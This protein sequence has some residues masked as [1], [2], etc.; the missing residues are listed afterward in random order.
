LE[1]YHKAKFNPVESLPALK[2][3]YYSPYVFSPGKIKKILDYMAE[4]AAKSTKPFYF[5]RLSRYTAFAL[6]A[7]CGLRISEVARLKVSDFNAED[8]T[9]FIEKSKFKKDRLIP[10]STKAALRI[11]NYV[12]IRNSLKSYESQHLFLGYDGIAC[13]RKNLGWY[14]RKIVRELDMLTAPEIKGN[15]IFGSPSPHSL[16]HSFAINT[17]TR[18]ATEGKDIDKVA[19]TLATYMGHVDFEFTQVY[20]KGLN[21]VGPLVF[22]KDVIYGEQ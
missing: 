22:N 3:L 7:A 12:T 10:V 13:N 5:V 15:I 6:Q 17:V 20:L 8:K 1:R 11:Q 21:K 2:E 4:R 9:I 16:R 18:W 14:F 19:D